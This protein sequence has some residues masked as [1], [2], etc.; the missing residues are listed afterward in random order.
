M[1]DSLVDRSVT[2]EC[3]LAGVVGRGREGSALRSRMGMN[4]SYT[5]SGLFF[6]ARVGE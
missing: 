4:V 5:I 1:G 6:F 2:V 3:P